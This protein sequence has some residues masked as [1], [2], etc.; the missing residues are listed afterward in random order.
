[1]VCVD[2]SKN[3]RYNYSLV[4]IVYFDNLLETNDK[5]AGL[6]TSSFISHSTRM[7]GSEFFYNYVKFIAI[8]RAI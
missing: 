8:G 5:V 1:M 4:P 7:S 6:Q 2:Y 3:D